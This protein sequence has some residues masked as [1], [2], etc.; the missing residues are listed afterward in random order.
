[1]KIHFHINMLRQNDKYSLWIVIKKLRYMKI[2]RI[3][4]W[5]L[6]EY[7]ILRFYFS[8]TAYNFF[9]HSWI[10]QAQKSIDGIVSF[11]FLFLAA[12][13]FIRYIEMSESLTKLYFCVSVTIAKEILINKNGLNPFSLFP[14]ETFIRLGSQK[15][16][17]KHFFWS[18]PLNY[19][20]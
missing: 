19:L 4:R 7:H 13:S 17:D 20:F 3:L 16:L 18:K 1:M 6:W 14:M 15:K 10:R 9:C 2:C 12:T 11:T 5:I 8:S